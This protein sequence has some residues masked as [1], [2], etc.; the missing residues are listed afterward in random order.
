MRQHCPAGRRGGACACARVGRAPGGG[1]RVLRR[2]LTPLRGRGWRPPYRPRPPSM[3]S[4]TLHSLRRRRLRRRP[5]RGRC[6]AP[7]P[8][9]RARQQPGRPAA[10]GWGGGTAVC[11]GTTYRTSSAR[12]RRTRRTTRL[13]SSAPAARRLLV[14]STREQISLC[15]A[16]AGSPTKRHKNAKCPGANGCSP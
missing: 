13:R 8:R 6:A 16:G 5:P 15:R 7:Q 1:V 9:R 12:P 4:P 11:H 3:L 10:R 2:S 14:R